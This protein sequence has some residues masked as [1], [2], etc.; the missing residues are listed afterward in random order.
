MLRFGVIENARTRGLC[1]ACNTGIL[2]AKNDWVAFCDDDDEWLPAK[3]TSQLDAAGSDS[4]FVAGGITIDNAKRRVDRVPGQPYIPMSR[5]VKS[6]VMEAHS[7]T[8]MIRRSAALGDLGLIDEEIPGGYYEDYDILL[9]AAANTAHRRC[10]RAG[11]G[12]L[13]AL[14]VFLPQS[15]GDVDRGNRLS[16]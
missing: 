5:L 9:R 13:L 16:H 14:P 10:R 15:L 12:R 2:E 8:F 11:G 7:S 3:L 6:R 4:I 1:A